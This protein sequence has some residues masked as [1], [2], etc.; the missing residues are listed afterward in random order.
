MRSEELCAG[1]FGRNRSG[2]HWCH[3]HRPLAGPWGRSG[4]IQCP[5]TGTVGKP[6][7]LAEVDQLFAKCY[8]IGVVKIAVIHQL[9]RQ[10]RKA[11][12][13]GN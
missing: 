1:I 5:G 11:T 12:H 9:V 10:L 4:K 7:V 3:R 2:H 13:Y 8:N 6:L